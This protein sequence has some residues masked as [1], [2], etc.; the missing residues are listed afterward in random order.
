M[1][2]TSVWHVKLRLVLLVSIWEVSVLYLAHHYVGIQKY[3]LV[4]FLNS[5]K[6]KCKIRFASNQASKLWEL[7][8]LLDC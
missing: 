2:R 6:V 7:H 3:E 1:H 8:V 4:R 5:N